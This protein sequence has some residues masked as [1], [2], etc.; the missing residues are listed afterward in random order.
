MGLWSVTYDLKWFSGLGE[1]RPHNE[2]A[3]WALFAVLDRPASFVDFGCGDGW[4]V[5][6]AK[7]AGVPVCVGVEISEDVTKVAPPGTEIVVADLGSTLDLER[8]FELVISWEVAEH[9]DEAYAEIFVENLARHTA[10]YL[11]F[12]AA[13]IGQG[14]FHHVNC[15]DPEYWREKFEAQGLYYHYEL[16]DILKQTWTWIVGPLRY[17]VDNVQIFARP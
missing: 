9:I 5:Y 2:A 10:K 13:K 4:L 16:T 11:V 8:G 15:Q 3:L 14:G 17:L 12:T 7:T 1:L 6:T